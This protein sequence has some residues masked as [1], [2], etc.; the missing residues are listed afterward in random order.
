MSWHHIPN[1]IECQNET[2][3]FKTLCD[4]GFSIKQSN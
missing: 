1:I 2:I 3:A 4:D